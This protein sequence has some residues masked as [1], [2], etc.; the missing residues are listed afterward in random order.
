VTRAESS[1]VPSSAD[2]SQLR[3]RIAA[4]ETENVSLARSLRRSDARFHDLA[5]NSRNV[6]SIV[7]ATLNTQLYVSPGYEALWDKS[8]ESLYARPK[9]WL[10]S[11]HPED[12]S[13]VSKA[14][15]TPATFNEDYRV[16]RKNGES[17]WVRTRFTPIFDEASEIVRLVVFTEDI[18]D[19]KR[20]ETQ[21][22]QSQKMDAVGRLAGGIAHDFNNLLTV[23]NGYSALLMERLDLSEDVRADLASI[24]RAG[25]RAA[26]LTAQLLSFSRKAMAQPKTI[27]LREALADVEPM[28]RRLIRENVELVTVAEATGLSIKVDPTQFE[29]VIMNLVINARDAIEGSGTITIECGRVDFDL[30]TSRLH[31]NVEPGPYAM[32]VVS[33]TGRGMSDKVKERIFEPFFTTKELGQGTG[34]GLATVYGIVKQSGGTI[35]VYSEE[36]VGTAIRIYLPIAAPLLSARREPEAETVENGS[37]TILLV[38]D[39]QAVRRIASEV[40]RKRGYQ[41]VQAANGEEALLLADST[42]GLDLLVTDV[43]MP[44]MGGRELATKLAVSHP[45]LKI[46]F[47]SGYTEN[48][49]I[50]LGTMSAG[51][52]HLPKPFSPDTLARKVSEILSPKTMTA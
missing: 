24:A 13:R 9:S 46:L 38:E 14:L 41:V 23:I 5:D 28:L 3:E 11:V 21:L 8:L 50:Q 18:G 32:L 22:V 34:L 42:S 29:Q 31:G 4:L 19:W 7:D 26:S 40:L 10:D 48:A 27:E 35:W 52:N 37:A 20:L 30:E 43:I 49:A 17:R 25:E 1:N 6:V 2:V 15:E 12:L 51:S 16:V 44:K 45:H 36:S 47:I 33:D 39:D